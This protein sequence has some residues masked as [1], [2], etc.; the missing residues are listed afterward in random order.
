MPEKLKKASEEDE[1][2]EVEEP[3]SIFNRIAGLDDL[4]VGNL[5]FS[6]HALLEITNPVKT[7]WQKVRGKN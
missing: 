4:V 3:E 5:R 2:K 7:F 1:I 6:N